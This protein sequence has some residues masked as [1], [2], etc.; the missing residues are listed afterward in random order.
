MQN[1]KTVEYDA[2]IVGAGPAGSAAATLLAKQGRRVALVEKESFP[3]YHVG[4]SLIPHCW[5]SLER[6]GVLEKL[7]NATFAVEK[8]SVQFASVDGRK[9]HSFYFHEHMDHECARTW[10]VERAAFD[11]MLAEHAREHGADVFYETP[12]KGLIRDGDR[13][14][15]VRAEPKDGDD[16]I[17]RAPITL[18]A[19]GRNLFSVSK[20]DWHVPDPEL[21]KVAVWTY[22]KGAKREPGID[23]GATTIA[24]LPEK[25]WFWYIPLADDIVSVGIVAE[26]DY[27]YR[28]ERDPK[29]IFDREVDIQKW[30]KNCVQD[31]EQVGEYRVTGD[32]SYRARHSAEDGLVLTGDAFA[33][34]D[35][36]FSSGVFL[37]L[38]T[39]VL[40]ADAVGVALDAGDVSASQFAG[41]SDQV[42]MEIEAMRKLVYAFYDDSFSFGD[43]V[44]ARPDLSADLTE[45]LIGNLNRDFTELFDAVSTMAD[46]PANLTHGRPLERAT[47]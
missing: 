24:Y 39:G 16:I 1:T 7:E 33:F 22:Y 46:L 28:G 19:S 4:E 6:M 12:V 13:V 2:V 11:Q 44:K 29:A 40:A 45:C 30:I 21:K 5:F 36:V 8:R 31:A 47:V 3:R 34:L 14:V 35:P 25:G 17:F 27:L 15:G 32:Y 42:C 20:T 43:L 37:A 10:Q 38:R 18:D 9:S 41:Y 26:R 23:G